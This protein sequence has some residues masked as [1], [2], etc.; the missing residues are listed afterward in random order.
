MDLAEQSTEQITLD[1]L[2]TLDPPPARPICVALFGEFS[3]GKSSLA[4]LIVGSDILPT[5]VLSSTR[6]LTRL[7]YDESVRIT[8]V[9]H[10]GERLELGLNA[11]SS[12]ARG[13]SREIDVGIPCD[14]LLDIELLDTPGLADPNH[15]PTPT[16]DAADQADLAIW[17]TRAN[18]AWRQSE[19]LVWS[20]MPTHL[21]QT[22]LLVVTRSDT[23]KPADVK[24]L[25]QRLEQDA[26]DLF[27]GIILLS[28]P[29]AVRAQ[30][31]SD[32]AVDAALWRR[33]GGEALAGAL[34]SS[35]SLVRMDLRPRMAAPPR[36]A[37]EEAEP[38]IIL[39]APAEREAADDD[40]AE[41]LEDEAGAF[42]DDD[43]ALEDD[44]APEDDEAEEEQVEAEEPVVY[45][46]EEE[47]LLAGL[48]STIKDCR[49]GAYVDLESGEV[50]EARSAF[51]P[52][53][54]EVLERIAALAASLLVDSAPGTA[55]H[56]TRRVGEVCDLSCED[57]RAIAMEGAHARHFL[58]SREASGQAIV[59][60]GGKEQSIG[61][62]LG[63]IRVKLRQ[64]SNA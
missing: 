13:E 8:S 31:T 57:V 12:A 60:V 49:L 3:A 7:H 21:H 24:R 50:L 46:T 44:D 30:G 45:A 42:E 62:I 27:H 36:A 23:L 2:A 11:V 48:M 64:F 61:E 16:L 10:D 29:D 1:R 34:L 4:N 47:A 32:D 37:D 54:A 39:G 17:C 25:A 22:G 58:I 33:S 5:S 9:S 18:Q 28:I 40:E 43:E 63:I 6:R 52:P 41:L 55:Q 51:G 53:P 56:L 38:V 59:L 26:G 20:N 14:R 19:R 35:L 15:D